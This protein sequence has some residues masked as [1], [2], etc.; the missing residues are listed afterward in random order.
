MSNIFLI[1]IQRDNVFCFLI[2]FLSLLQ[3]PAES[4]DV[5]HCF[6]FLYIC[7]S[8]RINAQSLKPQTVS[9]M[10]CG[11]MWC[12]KT[13]GAINIFI[14]GLV[15]EEGEIVINALSLGNKLWHS[16]TT[17]LQSHTSEISMELPD[18][19]C[20]VFYCFFFSSCAFVIL[21]MDCVV[22]HFG[23]SL[24]NNFSCIISVLRDGQSF[25][26]NHI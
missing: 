14:T 5:V 16:E 21:C 15:N 12:L 7:K 9:R 19:V 4:W 8:S 26:L 24:N 20:V 25:T 17:S 1:M 13:Q 10:W 23:T 2:W 22:M 6:H 3:C 11:T 18:E